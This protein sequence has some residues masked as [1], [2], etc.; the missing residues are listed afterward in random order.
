VSNT[1]RHAGVSARSPIESVGK[2]STGQEQAIPSEGRRERAWRQGLVVIVLVFSD[3]LFA[4]L[5]WG[6][7]FLLASGLGQ[8]GWSLLEITFYYMAVDTGLWLGIRLMSGLYSG[9]GLTAP[10][11][12]RRQTY[13]TVATLA[14]TT[15]FAFAFQSGGQLS[16]LL[17]AI[18][19]VER[20]LVA[21]LVRHFV[22]WALMRVGLWGKP[23]VVIG[24]GEMGGYLV[25][26]LKVEWALGLR[27]ISAF[28]FRL[29]RE[30]GRVMDF[31]S[32]GVFEGVVDP[33]DAARGSR[34]QQ[35]YARRADSTIEKGIN[36]GIVANTLRR[37]KERGIDT[38]IFAMP[39]VRRENLLTYV[40]VARRSF[41]H[42]I[43]IPNLGGV[44]SSAVTARNL[45]GTFGVEV[46]HNLLDPWALRTKRAL[47]LVGTVA[48]A[49]FVV[50]L[51][52][53]ISVAV[54]VDSRGAVL[55]R[56]QRMGKDDKSFSCLKFR[57]MALDAEE[58]LEGLLEENPKLREEYL[59]YHKLRDDPR[60]TRVGRFLRKTSLDE[61]PQLWNVLRGEMSLVGPRPYL[62]RE[63]EEVGESQ[64]EI[65]RVPPGMTGPWQ[66]AGRSH[67]SF[68]ERVRMDDHYVRNWSVWLDLILLARTVEILLFNRRAY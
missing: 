11:E 17:I 1:D 27:P 6:G 60:I 24:V 37:A 3:L 43:V 44:T 23:V 41:E 8:Q 51:L 9:Y 68:E 28:D 21:P 49:V 67:T 29:V 14:I 59:T 47:D 50:P 19:F 56:A 55:Y 61:L 35:A 46:K 39:H 16:R 18:C 5:A 13:G 25:R 10:D 53:V 34:T 20:L 12:L 4:S 40:A 52:I 48:G 31:P 15:L 45:A 58:K 57:T 32:D 62:H 33:A 54:R 38:A 30:R 65:L 42:V 36:R 64:E 66:V 63:S 2:S 7:A 26:R 22:K